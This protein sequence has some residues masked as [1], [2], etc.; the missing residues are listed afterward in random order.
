MRGK[1]IITS[2]EA[3][4]LF[5]MQNINGLGTMMAMKFKKFT[6][7]PLNASELMSETICA[8]SKVSTRSI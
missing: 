6:P 5:A 4:P 7:T 8:I 2:F 1:S 3:T